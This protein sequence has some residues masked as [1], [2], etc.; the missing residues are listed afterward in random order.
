MKTTDCART[1]KK[2]SSNTAVERSRWQGCCGWGNW[3]VVK[4]KDYIS[5][6]FNREQ[7][8]FDN[9]E[10]KSGETGGCFYL[11][12]EIA[13]LVFRNNSVQ[14]LQQCL[15]G[16]NGTKTMLY[17]RFSGREKKIRGAYLRKRLREVATGCIHFLRLQ[18]ISQQPLR[19]HSWM[20]IGILTLVAKQGLWGEHSYF[21]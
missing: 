7:F 12:T 6:F 8:V 2:N 11:R 16:W 17:V 1:T 21:T 13:L 19:L 14:P 4:A 15:I 18:K 3:I 5:T 10:T 20:S 9:G